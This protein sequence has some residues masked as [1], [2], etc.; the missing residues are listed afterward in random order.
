MVSGIAR[1]TGLQMHS[2]NTVV[3]VVPARG[4]SK[5][6]PRKNLRDLGGKPLVTWSIE[7]ANE[8]KAVDRTLV[9]TDDDEI[10]AVAREYGGE[11]IDR[12][13][14][15]A[16]DDSLV[17]DAVRHAFER[18]R[19]DGVEPEYGVLLEPTCPFRVPRDVTRCLELLSTGYDSVATF[20]EAAL[21]PH[22]AWRI[23]D[24]RPEPV[25]PDA[26][27]WLPRQSLPETYQLNGGCYAFDVEELDGDHHAL[28]FGDSGAVTMPPER[29]VDIDTEVDLATA[30]TL[31]AD[32]DG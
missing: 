17:I 8:T 25:I 5:T 24:D 31:V 14:S 10:A 6:V 22:R 1:D 27:P 23:E 20:T 4:G 19:E 28:L 15:L 3:A 2:D 16:A 30:R 29:S 18:I 11:V 13:P 21:N 9:S 12:P 26:D 32:G 7:V